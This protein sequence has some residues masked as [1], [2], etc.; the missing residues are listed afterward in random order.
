MR[1]SYKSFKTIWKTE[2]ER[3]GQH[4]VYIQNYAM[5]LIQIGG[6]TNDTVLLRHL[7]RKFGRAEELLLDRTKILREIRIQFEAV[8]QK[9]LDA[10]NQA[11]VSKVCMFYSANSASV[12]DFE[13]RLALSINYEVDGVLLKLAFVMELMREASKFADL[14]RS[15]SLISERGIILLF[16]TAFVDAFGE[17]VESSKERMVG[18]DIQPALL[19]ER[20]KR[21]IKK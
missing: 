11:N 6:A 2:F 17:N 20:A 13:N 9:T 14:K 10:T 21:L 19:Y 3:A 7:Y 1:V 8:L 12:E 5:F 18:H 16:S 4:F 15:D